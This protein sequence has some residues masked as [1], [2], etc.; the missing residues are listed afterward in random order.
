MSIYSGSRYST[1]VL[2]SNSENEVLIEPRKKIKFNMNNATQYIVKQG[3]T[4]DGIA[5]RLYGNAQ[6]WWAIM[7][8]NKYTNELE[9]GTGDVLNIP[10]YEEVVRYC[11]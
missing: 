9:I 2:Y 4:I 10:P 11:E 3:D 8:S 5:Y 6:L 1:S 7:D